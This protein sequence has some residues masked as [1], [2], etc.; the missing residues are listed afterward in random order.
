MPNGQMPVF[1]HKE[2]DTQMTQSNSILR[3]LGAQHG[4]WPANI[5][6][7]YVCDELMELAGD[8]SK[9]L[10]YSMYVGMRPEALGHFDITDEQK[11][12]VVKR[13]RG[14]LMKTLPDSLKAF[15]AKVGKSAFMNGGKVS[16]ADLVVYCKMRN[17][18]SGIIDHI[19]KDVMEGFENLV[20]LCTKV[21]ALAEVKAHYGM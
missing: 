1:Y 13:M 21:E 4:L 9:S 5:D 10:S 7:A 16:V 20:G 18:R 17:L 12:A 6:Q 19:P 2:T 3:F 14:D 15:D 11:A 8:L